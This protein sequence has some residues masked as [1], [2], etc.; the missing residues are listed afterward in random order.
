MGERTAPKEHSEDKE[1]GIGT[2]GTS[3]MK[4]SWEVRYIHAVNKSQGDE[5]QMKSVPCS[6]GR[7]LV[8]G[9]E[10]Q[11][12][13]PSSWEDMFLEQWSPNRVTCP[14]G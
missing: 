4:G 3:E 13:Y 10:N 1:T 11:T 12:L 7:L 2:Q 9:P 8:E 14:R 5:G 6:S